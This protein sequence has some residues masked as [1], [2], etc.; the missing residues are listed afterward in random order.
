MIRNVDK[1]RAGDYLRDQQDR[2]FRVKRV[3]AASIPVMI[4]LQPLHGPGANSIAIFKL[5]ELAGFTVVSRAARC[6]LWTEP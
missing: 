1:I 5:S 2:Y 3:S 4:V 6:A